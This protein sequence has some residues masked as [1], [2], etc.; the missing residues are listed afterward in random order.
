MFCSFL[1]TR[2][3]IIMNSYLIKSQCILAILSPGNVNKHPRSPHQIAMENLRTI[4]EAGPLE[5]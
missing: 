4:F 5:H 3:F 1:D 2:N